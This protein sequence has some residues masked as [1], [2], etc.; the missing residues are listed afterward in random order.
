MRRGPGGAASRRGMQIRFQKR[1]FEYKLLTG[2]I[3]SQLEGTRQEFD[4]IV[5]GSGDMTILIH[6]EDEEI[7]ERGFLVVGKSL[8]VHV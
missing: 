7:E 1:R 2:V 4:S 5:L 3:A 6:A 8:C